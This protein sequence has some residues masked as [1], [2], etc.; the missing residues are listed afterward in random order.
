MI[1]FRRVVFY[2]LL[3][4]LFAASIL[5]FCPGPDSLGFKPTPA[6]VLTSLASVVGI[7]AWSVGCLESEVMLTRIGL[8]ALTVFLIIFFFASMFT[9]E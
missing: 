2:V 3:A 9:P 4:G 8:M 6:C 5:L 1:I 7:L